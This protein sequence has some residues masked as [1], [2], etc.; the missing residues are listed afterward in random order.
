[1]QNR[2]NTTNQV[3]RS[4]GVGL[5]DVGGIYAIIDGFS[6]L[7][8][9]HDIEDNIGESTASR[10]VFGTILAI[11]V[12]LL[13]IHDYTTRLAEQRRVD[14]LK[15]RVAALESKSVS[16]NET[17]TPHTTPVSSPSHQGRHIEILGENDNHPRI[18]LSLLSNR[19]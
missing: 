5:M 18:E 1:M 3:L 9:D 17:A 11:G 7:I 12:G 8:A 2:L 19:S 10:C 14:E 16:A 13:A 4:L 15:A 6:K